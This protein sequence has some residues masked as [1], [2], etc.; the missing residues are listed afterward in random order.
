MP[1]RSCTYAVMQLGAW[2]FGVPATLVHQA[3]PY[4]LPDVLDQPAAPLI[5]LLR[6]AVQTLPV[7]DLALLLPAA[8][9]VVSLSAATS[10]STAGN[11]TGGAGFHVVLRHDG[12]S[13]AFRVDQ[14]CGVRELDDSSALLRDTIGQQAANPD[15][16]LRTYTGADGSSL[17]LLDGAH[18][19]A[20][21]QQAATAA[22]LST[23][24]AA[25][26]ADRVVRLL[27][28]MGVFVL[29]QQRYALP[30]ALIQEVIARPPLSTPFL[31]GGP[32]Q[33]VTEWRGHHVYAL[34]PAQLGSDA[35]STPL[36]AVIGDDGNYLGLPIDAA[37][38]LRRFRQDQ[39]SGADAGP[40]HAGQLID[41]DG[42]AIQ[43]LDSAA[44]LELIPHTRQTGSRSASSAPMQRSRDA[45]LVCD[46]GIRLAIPIRLVEQVCILPAEISSEIDQPASGGGTITWQGQQ[47]PLHALSAAPTRMLVMRYREQLLG[48]LVR[49]VLTL[50]PALSASAPR[51]CSIGGMAV[52]V[53]STSQ[54][55]YTLFDPQQLPYFANTTHLQAA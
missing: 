45:Y 37:H 51:A 26:D 29:G 27:P 23:S 18:L 10:H 47:L 17:P 36:L 11:D 24:A 12:A 34:A 14:L 38:T 39:L 30:A 5:G 48:L 25:H 35:A 1:A 22:G 3:R 19:I 9:E 2:Q 15:R 8:T 40:L 4:Q 21:A 42:S 55:S 31:W 44:L 7:I 28:P 33:G 46:A 20:L 50:L 49:D 41:E 54:A 53:I 32:L 43:L 52:S 6:N 16:L 13:V